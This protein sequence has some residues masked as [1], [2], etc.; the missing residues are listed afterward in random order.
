MRYLVFKR[1]LLVAC[2][3]IGAM[4]LIVSPDARKVD[5][6]E[7]QAIPKVW[8]DREIGSLELQLAD[9]LAS[10]VHVTSEYYYRIP[11]SPVYKSYLVY[12]P[13]KEPEGYMEWLKKQEPQTVF[14]ESKLHTAQDWI[15]AGEQVFHTS[16]FYDQLVTPED[17]RNPLWYEHTRVPVAKDGTVPTMR[18]VI[19]ERGKVELG[20]FSC[21]MCHTRVTSDGATLVGAQGNFPFDRATG[22]T[23]RNRFAAA[24][25]ARRYLERALFDAPWVKPDPLIQM[26]SMSIEEIALAHDEIPPGVTARFGSSLFYPVTVPDI[27]GVKD[28]K[29][30][31]RTGLVR[32][33]SIGDLMRYAAINQGMGDLASFGGF[34]PIA[35]LFKQLPEPAALP[36]GRYSD[37]QLYALAQYVYS[38]KAPKN[39]NRFDKLAVRGKKLFAGEGCASCHTPPLYTNN[40]LTPVEGF[41]PRED[42]GPDVLPISV[43]TDPGLALKT[44]RGTGYYKVPSLLGVWYRGPFE[45]SGSVATLEDWFDPNRLKEDYRPTGFRGYQV[46]TRAVKGHEYGLRL[47]PNDRRALIAFL[48]TL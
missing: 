1:L 16:L 7:S 48:K 22:F 11:V 8:D 28:K 21:A 5:T 46:K 9:P 27:I 13:G 14:D 32:N 3:A 19:R 30:L 25:Q 4:S 37:A 29:Y 41:K 24:V 31:D 43:G 34:I 17:V 42:M 2:S 6:Q 20:N 15:E 47:S 12:A 45:H 40:K 35:M 23:Y 18:Y 10:P 44:R 38:L 39:P 33:R 26:E 36:M